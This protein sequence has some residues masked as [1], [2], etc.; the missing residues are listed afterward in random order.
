MFLTPRSVC[1][2]VCNAEAFEQQ[3]VAD[4]VDSLEKLAVLDWL[5]C[6]SRRVPESDVI[7]VATKCDM[8]SR[9]ADLVGKRIEDAYR[10]WQESWVRGGMQPV[11]VEDGV[12]LTSCFS[13]STHGQGEGSKG[14]KKIFSSCCYTAMVGKGETS[15]GRQALEG[16]WA[17]D[18]RENTDNEPSPSLL[19]RLVNK[20]DADGLRGAQMVLPRSWDIALTVLEAFEFGRWVLVSVLL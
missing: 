5:R 7:L 13:T 15:T 20:G 4:D 11:R 19:Y 10:T 8:V 1:V 18:W 17:C 12:C 16:C 2:L 14:K 9:D 6:I 3:Q